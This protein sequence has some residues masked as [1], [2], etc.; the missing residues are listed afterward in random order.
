MN[1]IQWDKVTLAALAAQIAGVPRDVAPYAPGEYLLYVTS[2][3]PVESY[4]LLPLSL[5]D[6]MAWPPC[7]LLVNVTCTENEYAKGAQA[8]LPMFL[9]WASPAYAD[10]G[11]MLSL[12]AGIWKAEDR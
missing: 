6:P 7:V 10:N 5:T 12:T 3:D 2:V 1:T 9:P 4:G 11:F 8:R